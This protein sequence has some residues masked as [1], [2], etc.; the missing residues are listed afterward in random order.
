MNRER[1]LFVGVLA[2]IGLWFFVLREA[3][4]PVTSAKPRVEKVTL[5][6]VTAIDLPDTLLRMPAVHGAFTKVT[7]ERAHDRPALAAV[8]ARDLPNIWIPTSVS[9]RLSLLGRL[10]RATVAPVAGGVE[11]EATIE[12]PSTEAEAAANDAGGEEIARRDGWTALGNPG[13]GRIVR[14]TSKRQTIR[15]PQQVPAPGA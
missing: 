5:L 1:L 12:L 9:V 4:D 7:N 14:L 11:G 10:R 15:D 8:V 3:A 2:I 13:G 6:G